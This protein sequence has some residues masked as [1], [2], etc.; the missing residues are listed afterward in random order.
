MNMHTSTDRDM[1]LEST[2]TQSA[3]RVERDEFLGMKARNFSFQPGDFGYG[4]LGEFEAIGLLSSPFPHSDGYSFY[5]VYANARHE[6][7]LIRFDVDR[8]KDV[9]EREHYRYHY[10]GAEAY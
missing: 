4:N 10:S 7:L 6:R 9:Q 5:V 8:L 2:A 3:E 1:G